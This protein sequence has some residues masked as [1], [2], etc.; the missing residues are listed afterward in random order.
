[1][2]RHEG[3]TLIEIAMALAIIAVLAAVLTPIVNNYVD[4]AR[5]AAAQSDVKTIAESIS[6]FEKDVGRYP[7]FANGTVLLP[8][9]AATIIRLEGQGTA[10]TDTSGGASNWVNGSVSDTLDNQLLS[11]SPNYT[12]VASGGN[13]AAPFRWK[14]P[15][16]TST[17][18]PWGRKYLVNITN[19]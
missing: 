12:A 17:A 18:D 6:R 19:A 13:L 1:M 11:N 9:S 8:D 3:M 4:Q 2:R 7:M 14:G 5:V 16:G 15:Y 10:V